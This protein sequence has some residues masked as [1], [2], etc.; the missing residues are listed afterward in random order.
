MTAYVPLIRELA[1]LAARVEAQIAEADD[2]LT[3]RRTTA[4]RAVARAEEAVRQAEEE[5]Q[6]ARRD[7]AAVD[8]EVGR[9]WQETARRWPVRRLPEPPVPVPGAPVPAAVLLDRARELLDRSR[10]RA[11]PGSGYPLLALTGP[12]GSAVAYGLSYGARLLGERHGGELAVA[13]PVLGLVVALLGPLAGLLPARLLAERRHAI[14]DAKA[15]AAV[16]VPGLA[17]T[18]ALLGVTYLD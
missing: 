10:P 16:L 1:D 9:L 5:V 8:A 3:Q 11:L 15:V 18:A 2:W 14:L 7:V 4:D 17:T 6:A 13:M 12:A